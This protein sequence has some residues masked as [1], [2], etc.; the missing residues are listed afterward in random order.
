MKPKSMFAS[1]PALGAILGLSLPL[2]AFAGSSALAQTVFTQRQIIMQLQQPPRG[3]PRIIKRR[4]PSPQQG[5]RVVMRR[6]PEPQGGRV[7]VMRPPAPQRGPVAEFRAPEAHPPRV[8]KR[9]APE[10]QAPRVAKRRAPQP[11]EPAVAAR[12]APDRVEKPVKVASTAKRDSRKDVRGI[13]VRPEVIEEDVS[14]IASNYPDSGR[15]DLEIL[16][17]YDSDRIDPKSVRQLIILGEALNDESL[18]SERFVIAGHTDAAGSD[19]YNDDLSLRRARAVTE[20]LVNYAGVSEDRL[21]PEGYGE[22]LLKYPD[23]PNSGQ[24][25]RVEIINLGAG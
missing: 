21:E 25:R 7:Q 2:V 1:L 20:F 22:R 16:F 19:G 23:A 9:R 8:V 5:G 13:D 3:N 24:N 17:E 4:A 12:R 15:I 10:P 11:Q 6:A 14:T 18:G